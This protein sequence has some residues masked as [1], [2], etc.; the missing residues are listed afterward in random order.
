MTANMSTARKL[1][2][3]FKSFMEYKKIFM[4]AEQVQVSKCS[5]CGQIT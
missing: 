4:G 5:F 1:F 2:R 3:L